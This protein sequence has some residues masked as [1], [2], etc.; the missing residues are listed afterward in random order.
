MFTANRHYRV[1]AVAAEQRTAL[2]Q[3]KRHGHAA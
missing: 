3:Y 2:A 1:I